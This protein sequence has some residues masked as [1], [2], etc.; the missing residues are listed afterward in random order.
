MLCVCVSV[1]VCVCV[2]V[3]IYRTVKLGAYILADVDNMGQ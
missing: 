3:L 2:C 1:C